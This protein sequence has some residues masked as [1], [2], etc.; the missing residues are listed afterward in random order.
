MLVP[1]SVSSE[2]MTVWV[3]NLVT[4]HYIDGNVEYLVYLALYVKKETCLKDGRAFKTK[5]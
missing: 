5:I 1:S 2:G 4:T 3:H